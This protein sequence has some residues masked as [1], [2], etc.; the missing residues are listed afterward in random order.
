MP[1]VDGTHRAPKEIT[2]RGGHNGVASSAGILPVSAGQIWGAGWWEVPRSI[3]NAS[4]TCSSNNS[5]DLGGLD[6]KDGWAEE[7]TGIA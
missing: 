6:E 1:Q 3:P 2:A 7:Q 5:N 4:M